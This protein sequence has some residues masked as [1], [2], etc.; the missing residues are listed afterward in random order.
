MA[1][2]Y[3]YDEQIRRVVIQFMRIFGG[4][5]YKSGKDADGNVTYLT[6]PCVYGDGSRQA[7]QIIRNNSENTINSVPRIACYMSGLRYDNSRSGY[8]GNVETLLVTERKFDQETGKYTSEIGNRYQVDRLQPAPLDLDFKVDIWTTNSDQKLQLFE[9]IFILFNPD[10]DIQTT[11]S[12]LDWTGIQTVRLDE[13]I[14]DNDGANRGTDDSINVLSMSFTVKSY[15]NPPARVKRQNLIHTIIQRMG[16]RI[17]D[18]DGSASFA[19]GDDPIYTITTP[20]NH[21]VQ[22]TGDQLIL[23]GSHKNV[24]DE[25]GNVYSWAQLIDEYGEIKV[26]SSKIRLRWVSDIEDDTKDIIGYISYGVADNELIF[27]VIAET[28]PL[29]TLPPINKIINPH[30]LSP[31]SGLPI[32]TS[33]QYYLITD[34]I[35][36]GSINWGSLAAQPN[37]IIMFDGVNWVV[38]FP[39]S[40]NTLEYLINLDTGVLM[41]FIN[42]TWQDFINTTYSAGY[43]RLML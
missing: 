35:G 2:Q 7:N 8:Q 16:D 12:P 41:N 39:A 18:C 9:Q 26:G 43:F 24:L 25:N 20:G 22:L 17:D 42:H 36:S 6:V 37:D 4:F 19:N 23:L 27:D 3:F 1:V 34:E 32:A 33:G 40:S 31:G 13:I 29:T 5:K 21:A 30:E 28:L 14:W 10:L 38:S 15:L 11:S